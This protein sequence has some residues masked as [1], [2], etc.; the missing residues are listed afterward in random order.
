MD[1]LF[2][3]AIIFVHWFVQIMTVAIILRAI[4]S[5]FSPGADNPI[6]RV[7]LEVTEPLLAPLRR[8]LPSMGM[9]DLSPFVAILLLT[10]VFGPILTSILASAANSM[11]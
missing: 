4:F 1:R 2:E 8:I 7:L 5:W 10:Y 6:M 3:G 9:L 11:R